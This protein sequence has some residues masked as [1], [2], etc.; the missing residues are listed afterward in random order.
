MSKSVILQPHRVV[1][2]CF[3]GKA[4]E[5]EGFDEPFVCVLKEE[6]YVSFPI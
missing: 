3:R 5:V 1:L 4:Q 2:F 6:F